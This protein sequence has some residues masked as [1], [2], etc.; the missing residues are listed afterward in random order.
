MKNRGVLS[1]C[2]ERNYSWLLQV[3]FNSGLSRD[4]LARAVASCSSL[5]EAP[6]QAQQR[7]VFLVGES[8]NAT[9]PTLLRLPLLSSLLPSLATTRG[10]SSRAR[11]K[12]GQAWFNYTFSQS[13]LK[14]NLLGYFQLIQNHST[15]PMN[16]SN[17][18]YVIVSKVN[19]PLDMFLHHV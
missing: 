9:I 3:G 15:F 14:T 6:S 16:R 5:S 18:F 2:Q 17:A 7:K 13:F 1:V 19:T 10:C 4:L 8:V 11:V 12:V